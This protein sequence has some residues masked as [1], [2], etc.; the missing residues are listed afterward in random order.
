M[1]A[2]FQ[3]EESLINSIIANESNAIRTTLIKLFIFFI[4]ITF[5]EK[6]LKSITNF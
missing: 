2:K 3:R 1:A 5:S 6:L 4:I